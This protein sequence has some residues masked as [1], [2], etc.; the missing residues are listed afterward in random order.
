MKIELSHGS[1]M[2]KDPAV[3]NL[4]RELGQQTHLRDKLKNKMYI[5]ILTLWICNQGP[6]K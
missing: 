4:K 5:S 2:K 3:Y 1:F 6:T